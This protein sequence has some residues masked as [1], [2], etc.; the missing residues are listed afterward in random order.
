MAGAETTA[1]DIAGI[2]PRPAL[3]P[4]LSL[5]VIR[6]VAPAQPN[7]GYSALG[8]QFEVEQRRRI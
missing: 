7:R 2:A 5:V 6:A 8:M 1:V 3:V 4:R